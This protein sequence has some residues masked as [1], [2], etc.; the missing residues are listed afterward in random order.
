MVSRAKSAEPADRIDSIPRL[1]KGAKKRSYPGFVQPTLATLRSSPPT[2]A[3]WL[4]EIKFDGYRLQAHI[5]SG[6]VKLLTRSGLDWTAKFGKALVA[7][8]ADLKLNEAIID[9]EVVVEGAGSV[10]DFSALQDALSTE[11]T[12]RLVFYAFDL[13]YLDGYDF[14]PSPLIGRKTALAALVVAPSVVRFSEHFEEYGP[15]LLQHACRLGLEGVVSKV[16]DAPYRSGRSKDWIKSK[17]SNRQEFVIAGY[18]PSTVSNKAI[19]SLV[20]GYYDDGKLIH[21]GRVGTGF[22]NLVAAD[23]FRRLDEM[24][25]PKSPFAKK[26][27]AEDARRARFVRPELVAEV[28]FRSWTGEGLIRH[29]SFRGLRED[30]L[31]EEVVLE[32]KETPGTT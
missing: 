27:A 21:V 22:S 13:L 26:L 6:R 32:S 18:V 3:D 16:R 11:Q 17:C 28:E 10:A 1:P 24:V 9:G 15:R 19:G 12:D 14:R 5:R 8:L 25:I 2:G 29:A 4:H 20:L 23:L 31:A 30:K 7:A